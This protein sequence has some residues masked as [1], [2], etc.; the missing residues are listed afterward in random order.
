MKILIGTENIAGWM[1]LY[2]IG[3]E[4]LGH[5]VKTAVLSENKFYDHQYDYDL[6]NLF[7]RKLNNN[8][9][10]RYKFI[11]R[12]IRKLAN[13][14]LSIKYC[15]FIKKIIDDADVVIYIWGCFHNDMRDLFYAKSKKKKVISLFVG[16]DVR[17]WKAFE[18]EFDVSEWEFPTNWTDVS[19]ENKLNYVRISEKFADLI[20]SVPDQAGLQIRPYYHIQVPVMPVDIIYP[21]RKNTV[22]KILHTPS[23]PFKKGTDVIEQT[24]NRLQND[25][26]KFEFISTRDISNVELLNLIGEADIL[27]DEIVAPGPGALSFEAMMRGCAVAT[28]FNTG[29]H[30]S[31][32]PPVLYIDAKNIYDQLKF[33]I[34]NDEFRIKLA[35]DGREYALKNNTPIKIV[36]DIIRNLEKP[37]EPHYHP[38][39]LS[40]RYMPISEVERDLIESSYSPYK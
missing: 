14:F 8:N 40:D 15:F 22:L 25:G 11:S 3:F 13:Y 20:Y 1:N 16:S 23:S 5:E 21:K 4:E 24:I 9:I 2:K 36:S 12:L 34:L 28:R 37:E 7:L 6:Y 31:F 17:H 29:S 38:K 32:N 35:Q 26:L 19:I 27:V 18:Q 30:V 10:E 33:L 39:F